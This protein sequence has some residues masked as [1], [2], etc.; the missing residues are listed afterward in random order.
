VAQDVLN[1][2]R[3]LTEND[4]VDLGQQDGIDFDL[5]TVSG[6]SDDDSSSGLGVAAGV[7]AAGAA[8]AG[9]GSGIADSVSGTAGDL[10]SGLSDGIDESKENV[11]E[12]FSRAADPLPDDLSLASLTDGVDTVELDN[13]GGLLSDNSVGL[14]I[15]DISFDTTDEPVMRHS[16]DVEPD[17]AFGVPG[18]DGNSDNATKLDLAKAYRDMGDD[19]GARGFLEEVIKNGSDQQRQEAA[20]LISQIESA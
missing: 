18:S 1:L 11:R 8:V 3:S 13:D 16:D 6:S 5:D 19:V 7:A 20:D 9:L 2:D 10:G 15:D 12:M 14:D 17:S 4:E